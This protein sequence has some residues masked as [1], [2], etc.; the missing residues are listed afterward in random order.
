MRALHV[1]ILG[2]GMAH[3]WIFVSMEIG[4][5]WAVYSTKLQKQFQDSDQVYHIILHVRCR[6]FI[7]YSNVEASLSVSSS[8]PD[9]SLGFFSIFVTSGIKRPVVRGPAIMT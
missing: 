7:D 4:L 2:V 8:P 6:V 3:G 1:H 5:L 9:T